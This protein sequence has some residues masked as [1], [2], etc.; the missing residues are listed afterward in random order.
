LSGEQLIFSNGDL[1]QSRIRNFQRMSERRVMFTLSVVHQTSSEQL[2]QIPKILGKIVSN[3][4]KARF[5]RCHFLKFGTSSLDFEVV[6]WVRS[7]DFNLY[8][9]IAQEV[10]LEIFRCFKAEEI[11]FAYPSQTLFVRGG[12]G[13]L[14]SDPPLFE[15]ALSNH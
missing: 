9:D 13:A 11:Y 15:S 5:E 3:I 2:A 14:E 10:N 6:Y 12:L 4:P 7:P 8:A 1:L